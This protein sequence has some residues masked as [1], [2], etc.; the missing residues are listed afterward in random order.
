M[1][2]KTTI[3]ICEYFQHQVG[4]PVLYTLSIMI[5][6]IIPIVYYCRITMVI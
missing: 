2:N 6:T 5:A 4:L 3:G 1:F